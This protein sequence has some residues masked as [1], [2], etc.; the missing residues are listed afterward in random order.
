MFPLQ[1][2]ADQAELTLLLLDGLY[3]QT[4]NN[5]QIQ[6]A[7]YPLKSITEFYTQDFNYTLLSNDEQRNV[8]DWY[9]GYFTGVRVFWDIPEI[10][11]IYSKCLLEDK[12]GAQIKEGDSVKR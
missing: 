8:L 6:E 4:F 1:T 3:P 12:D 10:R 5:L 9:L 2:Q 11:E 7:I